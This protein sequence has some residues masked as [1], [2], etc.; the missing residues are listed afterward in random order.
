MAIYSL[1]RVTTTVSINTASADLVA[2]GSGVRPQLLEWA[3][4][5]VISGV[6]AHN[7]GL[8]R[9]TA[10]GTRT[11]PVSLLPEDQINAALSGITDVSMA[12]SFSAEPTEAAAALKRVTILPSS[13]GS[14]I[15]YRFPRP[16]ILPANAA[17]GQLCMINTAAN[18]IGSAVSQHVVVDI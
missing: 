12:V 16:L 1:A 7:L 6:S 5:M 11:S 4:L 9:T 3:A 8:F 10:I 2:V 15:I 17:S 13:I 18:G 14:G